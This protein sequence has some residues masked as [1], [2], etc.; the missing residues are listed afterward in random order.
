LAFANRKQ[1]PSAADER[2]RYELHQNSPSDEGYRAFLNRLVDPLCEV[3]PPNAQGLDFGC[4]PGPT[5]SAIMSERGYTVR[6]FDP[7]FF[8][9]A[10]Y[11]EQR[12]DFVTATEV[13][14]H[15]F[16]PATEIR[17][18]LN[19]IKPNGWLALMTSVRTPDVDF[20]NW[21][22]PFDPTHVA[23]FSARSFEWIQRHWKLEMLIPHPNVRLFRKP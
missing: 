2:S 17:G 14:E 5:L 19:L 15:M 9:D 20:E 1:L 6:N 4:G 13:L 3:L 18:L 7:F 22:Y 10:T 16:T 23:F 21:H 8:P 11:R 12:Y